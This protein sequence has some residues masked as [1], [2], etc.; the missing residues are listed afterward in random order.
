MIIGECQQPN[1]WKTWLNA[2]HPTA[3]GWFLKTSIDIDCFISISP[4]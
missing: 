3:V 2:H 1:E 4:T